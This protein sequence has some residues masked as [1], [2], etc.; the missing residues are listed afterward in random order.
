M[1]FGAIVI[2]ITILTTAV[3]NA[4]RPK[5]MTAFLDTV[6]RCVEEK[7]DD[8]GTGHSAE[9]VMSLRTELDV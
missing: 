8:I 1:Y 7:F 6:V 9:E 3:I 2:S 5:T 4:S